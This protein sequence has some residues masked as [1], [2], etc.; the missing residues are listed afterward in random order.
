MNITEHC[1]SLL[2]KNDM[3]MYFQNMIKPILNKRRQFGLLQKRLMNYISWYHKEVCVWCP[4]LPHWFY[5]HPIPWYHT[6]VCVLWFTVEGNSRM[7]KKQTVT[8]TKL[9]LWPSVWTVCISVTPWSRDTS[10]QQAGNFLYWWHTILC[11]RCDNLSKWCTSLYFFLFFRIADTLLLGAHDVEN[12]L[13][14]EGCVEV[15]DHPSLDPSWLEYIE[16][17]IQWHCS[18]QVIIYLFHASV[19]VCVCV[20]QT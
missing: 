12:C 4:C 9:K 5:G 8:F 15:R 1:L 10:V 20:Y 6:E 3:N 19:C 14:S 16:E 7:A 18:C 17:L 13:Q 2:L 11:I